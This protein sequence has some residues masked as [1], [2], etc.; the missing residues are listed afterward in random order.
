[1][2]ATEHSAEILAGSWPAQSVMSWSGYAMDYSQAAN[3]LFKELDTQADI[4]DILGPMEGAFIDSARGLAMGRET[5]LQNRIEA[6]RHISKKAHWA[7][8]E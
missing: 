4:K 7:A 2:P 5:A 3:R 8:N 6:Y 1:M